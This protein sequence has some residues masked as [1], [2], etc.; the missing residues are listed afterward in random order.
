MIGQMT[1][2]TE[3]ED[4]AVAA[5]NNGDETNARRIFVTRPSLPSLED[6]VPLLQKIWEKKQLTNNGP[7]HQQLEKELADFL[8]VEYISLFA[9]GMSALVIALQVLRVAGEVITTPYSFVATTHALSWNNIKPVFVD[10]E[11]D[12]CNLDP[13]KIEA[14]ITPNTTAI[15]PVHIY[16]NP[17]NIHRIQEI[18]DIYGLKVI[19]DAAHAF[20]VEIDGNSILNFGD[21]SML[22][23]H[24][25][26]PF[27]TLEGG[28]LV[29]HDK[30]TKERIDYAKNFGF[31][32]ETRV[33][34]PGMN[35]KMNEI[36][37]AFGLLQLKKHEQN[38]IKLKKIAYLYRE[39]L[40][41][42]RGIYLLK[43]PENVKHSYTYFPIFVN[44]KEYG[45]SRDE[46]YAYLKSFNIFG[47][48][49]FYPLISQFSP[50]NA[51]ESAKAG[52]MPI[53]EKIA[54][55]VICLPIYIDLE[56]EYVHKICSIIEFV[57]S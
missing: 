10:V 39:K 36:Q 27:N 13:E 14:A 57:D 17:C 26:K 24:A 37:A 6:F 16:G 18:A 53:A 44:E 28:A 19:Y 52:K 15:L 33:V 45:K 50:Y 7:F 5:R 2:S 41:G 46:L 12:Y 54:K 34:V 35:A 38:R 4:N 29:S 49:Y 48:R 8:G 21:L 9:N 55:Q 42:I 22:S 40:G 56:I 25:T 32:G 20:G 11:P 1:E 3:S 23:F 51:L 47:R 43:I 31:A 30:K